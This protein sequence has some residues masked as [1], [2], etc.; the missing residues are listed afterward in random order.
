MPEGRRIV[1]VTHAGLR[2][3]IEELLARASGLDGHRLVFD[4]FDPSAPVPAA[5]WLPAADAIVCGA[6]FNAYWQARWLG[7]E[8]RATFVPFERVLNNE[9]QR[10]VK[11]GAYRMRENGADQLARWIA[12]P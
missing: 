11:H 6:G 8:A 1:V 3:E 10:L 7:Y 5:E 4:L 2:G 9:H 12:A